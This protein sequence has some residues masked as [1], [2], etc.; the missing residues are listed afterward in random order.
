MPHGQRAGFVKGDDVDFV[1]QLQRLGI[2]DQN[3]E[4]GRHTG[5]R[6]DGGGRGQA[7][8]AGAGNHQHRHRA[9]HRQFKRVTRQPP[10]QQGAQRYHEYHRYK[11]RAHLIHQALDRGFGGLRVLHQPDDVGQHRLAA[12]R[13]DLH[14]DAAI[15]VDGA[16]G[17]RG[18]GVF[19]YRQRLTG[20]HGFV[21][22][23]VAF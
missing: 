15:A 17:Q 19:G 5:T 10:A 16:T 22:L 18:I 12:N 11:Y 21:H 6:H 20:E 1:G 2:L 13:F 4:F 9:N 14:H 8:R 7:K 3:A 23:G